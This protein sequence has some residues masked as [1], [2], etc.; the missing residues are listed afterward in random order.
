MS[1]RVPVVRA[2]RLTW[3]LPIEVLVEGSAAELRKW[4]TFLRLNGAVSAA[5]LASG[6]WPQKLKQ[7]VLDTTGL[8]PAMEAASSPPSL[9]CLGIEGGFNE[10][11][12]DVVL[13]ASLLQLSFGC[14]FKQPIAG[15]AWLS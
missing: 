11:V 9:E 3:G 4:P 12:V 8:G 10:P 14:D 15:V 13:P 2:S 7:F 1:S 5:S 6:I